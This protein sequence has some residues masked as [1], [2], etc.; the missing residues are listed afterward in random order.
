MQLS[1]SWHTS[2]FPSWE[3]CV[4]V[5]YACRVTVYGDALVRSGGLSAGRLAVRG[6]ETRLP[7]TCPADCDCSAAG[8]EGNACRKDPRVG[9]CVCKPNFQGTHCELCAPGFFGPGCQR[10]SRSPAPPNPR[11]D[12]GSLAPLRLSVAVPPQPASVLA[13]EWWTVTVT[14]TRASARAGQAS[15]G[16][17]ATAVPLA[18]SA[19]PSAS[20]RE[21]APGAW[22]GV[23][24]G[25]ARP[26]QAP[27][28]SAPQCVAA[29]P[30][31]PCP[32][33]ATRLAAACAGLGLMALTVTAA[34][35]ATTATPTAA[36][37]RGAGARA[38]QGAPTGAT[39]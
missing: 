32:R 19:S 29:A 36:V 39:A 35:P 16:P 17:R 1:S 2:A 28:T 3:F 33:A 9:R 20:V 30:Q 10:E 21:A 12:T 34:T 6:P 22:A 4:L 11:T 38:G 26:A 13:P 25:L 37:S 14:E 24:P 23:G 27:H 5:L 31:G 8:T 7:P 18:T 15:R